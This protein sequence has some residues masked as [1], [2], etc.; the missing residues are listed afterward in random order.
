DMHSMRSYA[1]LLILQA[2]VALAQGDFTAAAHHLET[3]V[4]FARHV[5]D[6]PSLIHRLV[7]MALLSQTA[8]AVADFVERPDAPNLYWALTALPRPLIDLRGAE[9][10]EYR[11]VEWQIPELAGLE[12]ERPPEQWDAVLRRVR[13]ELRKLVEGPKE[14]QL[15]RE[16]FP[17]D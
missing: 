13:T 9:E 11:M 2:R 4:A 1:P 5:A 10:W 3:S 7:A 12:R 14:E 8:D 15:L 16:R 17:K 6:G